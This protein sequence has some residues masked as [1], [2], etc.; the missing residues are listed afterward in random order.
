MR[1]LIVF[2][3]FYSSS[4]FSQN[5]SQFNQSNCLDNLE[6]YYFYEKIL[7]TDECNEYELNF[8]EQ[9]NLKGYLT[10]SIVSFIQTQSNQSLSY[11][12]EKNKFSEQEIF[13]SLSQSNSSAILY[14]PKFAFCKSFNNTGERLSVFIYAEK[15]SFDELAKNYFISTLNRLT[16]N[17]NSHE[18]YYRVNPNFEFI[19]EINKLTSG[20]NTLSSYYGL[21]VSLGLDEN[22][23]DNFFQL[24]AEISSFKMKINSL[25][26]NLNKINSLVDDKRYE[27]A[28][29]FLTKVNLRYP[30]NPD[31]EKVVVNYNKN[32]KLSKSSALKEMKSKST[33]FNNFT[34]ELGFNSALLNIYR[35]SSG[36]E[37]YNGN[38]YFDRLYPYIETRFVFND[39]EHKYGIGPFYRQHFSNTLLVLSP[40]EYYFPFSNSFSEVGLFGQY[41]FI[42]D[43]VGESMTS[44]TFS[45]G[46]LLQSFV[47]DQGDQLNF[48]TFSPGLK[49]YLQANNSKSYRTSLSFKYNLTIAGKQFTYGNFSIGFS[50]NIKVGR[51]ISDLNKRKLE[52]DFKVF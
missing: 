46:K 19:E 50:R 4:V 45:T 21:M 2:L 14:N 32:V 5:C 8:E 42:Y 16:N 38:S 25:E 26:N 39:R 15:K 40:R 47:T 52:N 24:E 22:T 27:D 3:L 31:V 9:N 51:K 44:F 49:T 30:K 1:S 33:S 23:L 7:S 18:A 41:F 12:R 17:L 13:N 35:G 36:T 28:F 43:F 29:D 10:R 48:W 6:N 11:R 34:I 37:N 20:L